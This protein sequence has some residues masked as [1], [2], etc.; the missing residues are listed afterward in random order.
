M[1]HF[2]AERGIITKQIMLRMR[3]VLATVY[4]HRQRIGPIE[5]LH[6][7][8]GTHVAPIPTEGWKPF[9]LKTRWGGKD[10]MMWFRMTA[11]IPAEMAGQRVVAL[12]RPHQGPHGNSLAYLNGMPYQGLDRNRDEILLAEKAKGGERFEIVIESIAAQE[13]ENFHI[14][15]YADLAVMHPEP[16]NLYWDITILLEVLSQLPADYTPRQRLLDL[17]QRASLTVDIRH[18][19]TPAYYE[20]LNRARA[21]LKEGLKA[22]PSTPGLGKMAIIGH[23]HIDTA[24]MWP[25]RETRRKIA[26]TVSNALRLM[27]RYPEFRFSHSQPLQY[28]YLAKDQPAL[29]EQVKRRVK[30]GRWDPAGAFYV[31]PDCNMTSAESMVRQF[32]YGIRFFRDNFGVRPRMAWVPDCF[33]FAWSMPQMMRKAGLEAFA[34]TKLWW[35]EHTEFPYSAFHWEGPDGSRIPTIMPFSYGSVTR[36][37]EVTEHF[38]QFK[39]KD[40]VREIP[41]TV[42]WG[43]GGGGPT[44]EIVERCKRLANIVGFPESSFSTLTEYFKR[45]PQVCDLD[46]LPVWNSELYLEVHR[47]CQTAQARTKRNN[48]KCEHGLHDAE[49]L[50]ALSLLEG[51]PYAHEKLRAAWE[52]VLLNQFHD[53]LPGSSIQEVYTTADRDYA[54]AQQ[55][56]DDVR[57]DAVTTLTRRIA[58]PAEGTPVVVFNTLSWSRSGIVTYTG[59]RPKGTFHVRRGDGTVVAHQ[60]AADGALLFAADD[61]PPLG[62][63]TFTLM[64]GECPPDITPALQAATNCLENAL[65]RVTLDGDGRALSVFDKESAREAIAPGQKGNVLQLFDDRPHRSNAWEVDFNFEDTQWEPDPAESV[66]LVESGPLRAVIRV[67]RRNEKSVITQDITLCAGARRVEFVTHVDWNEKQ[68]LLKVAFPVDIRATRAT[69]EIQAAAIERATHT[70]HEFEAAEFEVPGLRWADLSEGDYGVSLLNDCKYGWDVKGNVLRLSLLRA[71]IEPD[72]NA[73]EGE[74]HFT[75]A[76]YPHTG[77]WRNGTVQEG[78]DLNAPLIAEHAAPGQNGPLPAEYAFLRVDSDRLVV[79][80]IKRAEDSDAIVVRFYEA[81]GHR[82]P[83]TLEFAETP[84]RVTECDLLE[85]NDTPLKLDGNRLELY[86]KPFEIRTIKIAQ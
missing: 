27:D 9:A 69:F 50:S 77:D 37:H 2:E 66:D 36:I 62:W 28:A 56:I 25:V 24:W 23:S 35:G 75:Y 21:V 31:E 14:F 12:I 6:R 53:I 10:E 63:A 18:P 44:L 3:E 68:T 45:L 57:T 80:T 8:K 26:R 72:P 39:Q 19:R 16:W 84:R 65:L 42:G 58:T 20:S 61:V 54:E 73:D 34:T 38:K 41:Y 4:E 60:V 81:H 83:V 70:N 55:L 71:S 29:F 40:K 5:A 1:S 30:E 64:P 49:F 32:M 11:E 76:L 22:F 17:V 79:D 78:F 85:E 43:D 46:A 67:R 48:R 51:A 7:G 59:P 74:H 47:G 52:I 13:C 15:E 86:V 33:G 82:G